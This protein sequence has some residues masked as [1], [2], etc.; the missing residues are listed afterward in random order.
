MTIIRSP[1]LP[2]GSHG[3]KT[4]TVAASSNWR[5][6]LFIT[7]L[8][9][10]ML[11]VW[12]TLAADNKSD[13]PHADVFSESS[14]PSATE[15]AKCHK[16]IYEEWRSSSH[17]YAAI[18][19]VFH[20]FEQAIN[21]LAPTIGNF[22]V[23]CHAQAGTQMGE[24]REAPLWER[25]QVSREGITCI[26]C[27]RVDEA[28]LKVNGER[29]IVP[30]DMFQPVFG[31]TGGK[32]VAEVIKDKDFYK[33]ATAK[34]ERGNEIHLS[35]IKFSQLDKSE[36]CGACH[37]VAV[38]LGI[39]LEVVWDQYRA[40]PARAAGT[41]CQ[42]CHMSSEPG[43]AVGF[44]TGPAAVVGGKEFNPGRKRHNHAMVGPGYPIAH[45]GIFPHNGAA[46]N[47]TIE[48]WLQ[49]DYRAGWGTEEFEEKVDEG[50]IEDKF[51]EAWEDVGDREE[52]REIIEDNLDKIDEK[53]DLRLQAMENGSK[54]D[55]P[56]FDGGK[57]VGQSLA[58]SYK[59][60]NINPG[61]NLPSGSLGAQPEIWLNVALI[62][63][64][65]KNIW[66]SGYV[67]SVGDMADLH[68]QDVLDGKLAHDDQLFNLQTK[69]LTTNVKGTDREMYLPVNFDVDQLPFLR[70][71]PQP[72][73]VINHP[74][75][76]RMEGRSI[77]PLGSRMAEYK[78]P[79][80]LITKP[81]KYRLAVRMRSRAEPIYF[82]KF[83]GAT[84]DMIRSMNE[85][86]L[87]IHPYT[88]EF[89][90]K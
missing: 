2:T 28:Y 3:M 4:R 62:D 39:K 56:F 53:K 88:V 15:C 60:T 43:K 76:V 19:P 71:A 16:D 49:F 59:I 47:W 55:G 30:G 12:P 70:P 27:H 13:D 11:L 40:S 75:F 35:A 41:T 42:D 22:C 77:P 44:A 61:H 34:G 14:Y 52:A 6:I 7:G 32:G 57:G 90:V 51:P 17:A 86:M 37:Q 69:F 67:D 68:S 78:V 1:D 64:D 10:V 72:T 84:Q 82:M 83:I 26:T 24:K 18:S 81:G 46:E 21:N 38:N 66:E 25:S 33:V 36:F 48:E 80:D 54:I 87:D 45:P 5:P 9:L 58:F 65:G 50:E 89:E 63:P 20:K 31:P 85:W 8:M 29:R 74:P 23:R 79:G 73:T